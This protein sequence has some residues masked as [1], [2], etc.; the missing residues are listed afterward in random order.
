MTTLYLIAIN[1]LTFLLYWWDKRQAVYRGWRIPEGTLLLLGAAG[2]SP[3]GFLAQRLLRHKNRKT[4]F[5]LAF[6]LI[7]FLQAAALFYF[8]A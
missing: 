3:A 5:Q 4:S 6:W 7:T 2:G 1:L 8:F